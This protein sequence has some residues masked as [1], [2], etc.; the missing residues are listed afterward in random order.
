MAELKATQNQELGTVSGF[1]KKGN[2]APFDGPP[3]WLSSDETIGTVTPSSDGLSAT[4]SAVGPLGS[5]MVTV[6]ADGRL[7]DEI[8]PAIGSVAYNVLAGDAVLILIPEGL[9]SEQA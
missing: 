2:D 3:S 4:V 9:I 6:T 5:F 7:G 8:V 1:D